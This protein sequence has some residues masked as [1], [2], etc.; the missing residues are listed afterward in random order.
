MQPINA[1]QFNQLKTVIV[2]QG[3][4]INEQKLKFYGPKEEKIVT[5]LLITDKISLAPDYLPT[6]KADIIR[7][8]E[9]MQTQNEQGQ[10]ST[11]WVE[12]FKRQVRGRL[13]FAGFVLTPRN[14]TYIALKD[15]FYEALHP[16]EELFS[17]VSWRG[18][19]YNI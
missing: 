3:F 18:F 14:E 2:Q 9:I 10:L 13:N 17:A 11:K 12:Q 7:L 19:P 4:A 6:L 1:E 16:P 8:K 5:G 15:A